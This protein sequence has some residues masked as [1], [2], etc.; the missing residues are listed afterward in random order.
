MTCDRARAECAICGHP[1]PGTSQTCATCSALI[2]TAEPPWTSF[3]VRHRDGDPR[4]FDT[5]TGVLHV[6]PELQRHAF[7]RRRR[8]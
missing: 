4:V 3:Y 7:A 6:L 5:V 8:P 2:A 1:A